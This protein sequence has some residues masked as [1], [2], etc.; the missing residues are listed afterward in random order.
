M[1]PTALSSSFEEACRELADVFL[2]GI[3]M[4]ENSKY[5]VL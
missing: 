5:T 3:A 1:L 4:A 2:Y